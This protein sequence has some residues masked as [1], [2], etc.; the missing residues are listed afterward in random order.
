MKWA[1]GIWSYIYNHEEV[2]QSV[3]LTLLVFFVF[4]F[5]VVLLSMI[6][7]LFLWLLP[8][9]FSVTGRVI[10]YTIVVIFAAAIIYDFR[11]KIPW[12]S[13]KWP[14]FTFPKIRFKK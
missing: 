8:S 14:K 10:Y 3:S 7:T 2:N 9:L 1:V 12:P 6:L 5:I 11:E 4:G 13:F